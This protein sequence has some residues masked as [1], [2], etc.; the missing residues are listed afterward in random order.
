[1]RAAFMSALTEL[2][3]EDK[4]IVLVTG[5]LGFGTFEP[6]EAEFPGQYFNAGIAEQSMVGIASGLAKA[7]KKVFVYSIGN[8]VTL[9][10]LEQIRNDACYHDL[11]VNFVSQGGGFTYGALGMSHHATEDLAI[12]RAV[13]HIEVIAPSNPEHTKEA[14]K[15]LANC[16]RVGYLRLEK[17]VP[18]KAQPSMFELG[19]P[20]H[21][22]SKEA[23]VLLI[24]VGSIVSEAFD[25]KD[26]LE[27]AGI[28]ASILDFHSIS[29]FD[30][31]Y[32]VEILSKYS[33]VITVEEHQR[34]GGLGSIISEVLVDNGITVKLGKLAIDNKLISEVGSQEYLR[35]VNGIDSTSI[36]ELVKK[37][38]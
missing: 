12:M 24:G 37:I 34:N 3:R 7:G 13:P 19:K 23:D 8:F 27:E 25:A 10:C 5:D 22:Q 1:M 20:D 38:K 4:D 11:N 36:Y 6:F 18:V 30:H 26:L 33:V 28:P 15:A 14:T 21:H 31:E 35:K 17:A 32:V 9:R 2:A 16:E 29:Y